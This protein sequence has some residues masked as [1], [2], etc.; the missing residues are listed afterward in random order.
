MLRYLGFL[1]ATERSLQAPEPHRNETDRYSGE[2]ILEANVENEL[3][4]RTDRQ[5]RQGEMSADEHAHTN[6][7]AVL[8]CLD[9]DLDG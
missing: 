2:I 6:T 1:Q 4:W 5:Q 9:S 8:F 3:M 7:H